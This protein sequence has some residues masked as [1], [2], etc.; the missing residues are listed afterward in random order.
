MSN[1]AILRIAKHKNLGGVLNLARHHTRELDCENVNA[2]RSSLNTGPRFARDAISAI[3][4]RIDAAQEAA[5]KKFRSDSVKVL[6]Y[7]CTASPEWWQKASKVQ[8]DGFVNRTKAWLEKRHPGNVSAVWVHYDE[9]TPHLHAFV[10]PLD[11]K[12]VLNAKHFVGGRDKLTRLQDEFAKVVG[13]PMGLDRGLRKSGTRHTR[14]KDFWQA[15][16]GPEPVK[17]TKTDYAKAALG[18]K[19]PAVE[20]QEK[21]ATM[22]RA[23][24]LLHTRARKATKV[25]A[26]QAREQKAKEHA[27]AAEA[28]TLAQREAQVKAREQEQTAL[29]TRVAHAEKLAGK[30]MSDEAKQALGIEI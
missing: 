3:S 23:G 25:V 29:R 17:P 5:A 12:G 10:V 15:M 30:T 24:A 4:D 1:F 13:E 7:M 20:H 8:R 14:V 28:A 2:A 19:T 6:E 11:P 21:Q 18:I 26:R 22:G 9:T 16:N 27:L